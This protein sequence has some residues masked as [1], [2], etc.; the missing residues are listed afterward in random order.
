VRTLSLILAHNPCGVM[1]FHAASQLCWLMG[2][3]P[4]AVTTARTFRPTEAD[5]QRHKR[6]TMRAL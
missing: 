5:K 6:C 4:L 1:R 3:R 2:E